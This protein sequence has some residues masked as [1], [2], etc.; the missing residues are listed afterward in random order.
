M[1]LPHRYQNTAQSSRANSDDQLLGTVGVLLPDPSAAALSQRLPAQ[2]SYDKYA[3][4]RSTLTSLTPN[5]ASSS[6]WL[7]E[8]GVKAL[9][10]ASNRPSVVLKPASASLIASNTISLPIR[11]ASTSLR[12]LSSPSSGKGLRQYIIEFNDS[13]TDVA[14]QSQQITRRHR[15][16]L[17]YVY[18]HSLRGFAARFPDSAVQALSKQHSIAAIYEDVTVRSDAVR[19][20]RTIL[21]RWLKRLTPLQPAQ[22]LPW[23]VNRVGGAKDGT[24]KTVWVLDT[25]VDYNHPD[26]RVDTRRAKSFVSASATDDNGHGTHVAGTIAA[27]D[28]AI[29]VVG[30]AAGAT[31]VPVKV[32]N[33]KGSG[34]LSDIIAGVD[35]IA[36]Y[37]QAGEVVNMSLGGAFYQPL[38]DA[39][40]RAAA[41]GIKFALAAG[42]EA[43]DVASKSPASVDGV[44][45]FTV[46]AID[47]TDALASFSNFGE[48]ID[49][50]APGVGIAST[51]L[52]SSYRTL[53]GTSMATPHVA[54]LLL[55]GTPGTNGVVT[56]DR[57]SFNEGIA[58]GIV[59]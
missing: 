58:F 30:V 51:W 24:G 23:G 37:A 34:Y 32:L 35:H 33:S 56:N 59:G 53:S 49:Y 52:G 4:R 39:I 28:N 7:T 29:G 13:V 25:G 20:P 6:D 57:D 42:N 22:S 1:K 26:L 31:V 45:V 12:T 14:G 50:A 46:S 47:T 54:G 10:V 9:T 48:G 41:K 27:L 18:Q 8:Y 19:S 3:I 16:Q 11:S 21:S 15:G 5:S 2:T 40:L 44:N 55:L 36:R 43:Q 38:N 17:Q